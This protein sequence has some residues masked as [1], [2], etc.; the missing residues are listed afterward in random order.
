MVVSAC[1]E[2]RTASTSSSYSG[3]LTAVV[4]GGSTS[5]AS[6]TGLGDLTAAG[7]VDVVA[8]VS[9]EIGVPE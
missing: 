6:S 7:E 9:I 3:R 4:I 8:E 5:M 2:E 1:S